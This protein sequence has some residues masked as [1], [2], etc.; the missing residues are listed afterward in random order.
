MLEDQQRQQW[1]PQGP[2]TPYQPRVRGRQ[3]QQQVGAV[4][5]GGQQD[6]MGDFQEQFAKIADSASHFVFHVCK[7]P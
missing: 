4:P 2:Q 6:T 5:Q 1:Q 7:P 3:P